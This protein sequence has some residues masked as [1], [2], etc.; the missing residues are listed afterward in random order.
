MSARLRARST[1]VLV[2]V[3]LA[4]TVAAGVG[5]LLLPGSAGPATSVS[6]SPGAALLTAPGQSRELVAT[7]TDANGSS[8][9]GAA[10]WTSSHADIVAVDGSGVI[11]AKAIGS[12]QIT[13]EVSGIRSEPILVLVATPAPGV[14]L[15]D[16]GA[17][18][19]GPTAIDP[20]AQRSTRRSYRVWLRGAAPAVGARLIG[21]GATPIAGEVVAVEQD[22]EATAVTLRLV[23]FA[24]LLPDLHIEERLDLTNARIEVPED[25]AERY[26]VTRTGGT[27]TFTPNARL[28]EEVGATARFPLEPWPAGALFASARGAPPATRHG[29]AADV[30]EFALGPLSCKA[31]TTDVPIQLATAPAFTFELNPAVDLDWA[32]GSLSRFVVSG[33]FKATVD[34]RLKVTAAFEGKVTCE[35]DLYKIWIPVNGP[36]SLFVGGVVPVGG[37]IDLSGKVTVATLEIGS[38]IEA[39]ATAELGLE[40]PGV[41]C[42]FKRT[43]TGTTG[44]AP[45]VDG[46]SLSDLRLEPALEVSATLKVAIGSPLLNSLRL[47][48]LQGKIGGKLAS[49]WAPSEVQILDAAYK[50]EFKLTFE[51]A[52]SLVAENLHELAEA[53]GLGTITIADLKT[54]IDIARSPVGTL[55]TD[56]ASY[57]PGETIRATVTLDPEHLDFL[58]LYDVTRIRLVR[59]VAG[60][61]TVLGTAEASD[62]QASFELTTTAN[63]AIAATELHAFVTTLVPPLDTFSLEL[64]RTN[65]AGLIAF[66]SDRAN[67]S[68][69]ATTDIWVVGADGREPVQLT[70]DPVAESWPSWSPDGKQIAFV[71]PGS[72]WVMQA[73]GSGQRKLTDLEAP[74]PVH[75]AWSPDGTQIAFFDLDLDGEIRGGQTGYLYVMGAGGN[76]KRLVTDRVGAAAWPT[77]SA[78]GTQIAF[79]GTSFE[80]PQTGVWVVPAAGGGPSLLAPNATAPAWSPDGTAIAFLG[81]TREVTVLRLAGGASRGLGVFGSTRVAWSGD[82]RRL[83]FDSLQS[84]G[85][86]L[87]VV[88]VDGTGATALATAPGFDWQP[89]W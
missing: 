24:E 27:V 66:A 69:A 22:G 6:I 67:P 55:S 7:A 82:G 45:T 62:G 56:K 48:L 10:T 1:I 3:V 15:V 81:A 32:D 85:S 49:T 33:Q 31:S 80:D 68:A 13:A 83:V 34:G 57:L 64:D 47:D 11:T 63:A 72:I 86:D 59:Y 77:W 16:D 37:A 26:D 38:K 46:P 40:C 78:D 25:V 4:A 44:F 9:L 21:T 19:S 61:E 58:L 50:S 35:K 8:K 17:V 53:L 5:V 74:G 87:F 18:V 84:A 28:L 65:P 30:L 75:V 70:F 76:G 52:A 20:G 79:A 89:D 51:A 29:P 39:Q 23:P 60:A 43:L 42:T 41:A 54:S 12:A 88:N 36:A 14:V 73:D 2:A 71:K